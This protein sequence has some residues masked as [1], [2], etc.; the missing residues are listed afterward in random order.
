[1]TRLF[2]SHSNKDVE[3]V[4]NRLRPLF[5][6]FFVQTQF[7]PGYEHRLEIRQWAVLG[8]AEDADMQILDNC[9]S[10]RHAK[11]LVG[12]SGGQVV[13]TITDLDSANGTFVSQEQVLSSHP[14]RVGDVI[15]MGSVRLCLRRID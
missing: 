9:V 3:F 7:G 15:E 13:L 12:R 1:M 2:I 11:I 5:D 14:L 10:R 8:R 6:E 4:R